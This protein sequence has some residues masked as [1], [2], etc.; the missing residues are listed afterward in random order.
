[1]KKTKEADLRKRAL[2]FADVAVA[3]VAGA[4]DFVRVG[5]LSSAP[6]FR[7]KPKKRRDVFAF[8]L[9]IVAFNSI[10]RPL[11]YVR[12]ALLVLNVW[13]GRRVHF[14]GRRRMR[15]RNNLNSVLTTFEAS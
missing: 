1:M 3:A 7:L 8:Y 10:S 9:I 4:A 11:Y 12:A 5:L 15:T 2:S 14:L 13:T 6:M